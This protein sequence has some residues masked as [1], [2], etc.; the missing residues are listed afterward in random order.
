MS[1]DERRI[2]LMASCEE[3]DYFVSFFY[4]G[5]RG[6]VIRTLLQRAC[7]AIEDESSDVTVDDIIRREFKIVRKDHGDY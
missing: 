2:Q 1:K 4:D 3:Y 7:E 6:R 5:V